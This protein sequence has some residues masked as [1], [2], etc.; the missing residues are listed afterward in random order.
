MD[1]ES[2]TV[3]TLFL[4]SFVDATHSES[5]KYKRLRLIKPEEVSYCSPK[6]TIIEPKKPNLNDEIKSIID[7]IC[8]NKVKK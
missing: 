6:V 1:K 7:Y 4:N 3:L 8:A 5:I 2:E